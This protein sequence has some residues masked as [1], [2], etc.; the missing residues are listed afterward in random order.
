MKKILLFIL[1]N[2][3]L[4]I[5]IFGQEEYPVIK[6]KESDNPYGL[7]TKFILTIE[8]YTIELDETRDSS[9]LKINPRWIKSIMVFNDRK[10]LRKAGYESDNPIVLIKLRKRKWEE[11]PKELQERFENSSTE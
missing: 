2:F 4:S 10:T 7:K 3:S 5:I 6:L 11:L 8:D 9:L 1:L